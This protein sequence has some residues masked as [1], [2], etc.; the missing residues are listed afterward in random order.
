[1]ERF[2]IATKAFSQHRGIA[3]IEVM[4][5]TVITAVGVLAVILLLNNLV[6]THPLNKKSAFN[7][8]KDLTGF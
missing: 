4:I 7:S 6:T 5:T 3:I 2:L 8:K 1:M